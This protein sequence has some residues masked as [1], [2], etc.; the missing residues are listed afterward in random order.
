VGAYAWRCRDCDVMT[1]E[2]QDVREYIE[3]A[4]TP[5]GLS[6]KQVWGHGG[7]CTGTDGTRECG[8]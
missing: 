1:V 6:K 5:Y 7:G 8:A 2:T 4:V 3:V